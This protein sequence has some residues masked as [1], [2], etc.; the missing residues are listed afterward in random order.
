MTVVNLCNRLLF[1]GTCHDGCVSWQRRHL[2]VV[3]TAIFGGFL[4]APMMLG[5][6][7][8]RD[9][10]HAPVTAEPS[11]WHLDFKAAGALEE[12]E[13]VLAAA[14]KKGEEAVAAAQQRA[15]ERKAMGKKGAEEAVAAAKKKAEEAEAVAKAN[16]EVG[17]AAAKRGAEEL[18]V[19]K[20]RLEEMLAAAQH[21]VQEMEAA[22]NKSVEDALAAALSKAE[23]VKA[24]AQHNAE[25]AMAAAHLTAE[26]LGSAAGRQQATAK[27]AVAA[28]R[29]RADEMMAAANARVGMGQT[30]QE[31][32]AMDVP[33]SQHPAMI[34]STVFLVFITLMCSMVLSILPPILS[35]MTRHSQWRSFGLHTS[36]ADVWPAL[37]ITMLM[38]AMILE[39]LRANTISFSSSH[40]WMLAIAALCQWLGSIT[41]A[42]YTYCTMSHTL[43]SMSV[44]RQQLCVD[45]A[46]AAT[47]SSSLSKLL[48]QC[49]EQLHAQEK[50]IAELK[51]T[52][53]ERA[54]HH[55][56]G[57]NG[58][59]VELQNQTCRHVIGVELQN[60]PTIEDGL[61]AGQQTLDSNMPHSRAHDT[62]TVSSEWYSA[63]PIPPRSLEGW[64]IPP[65]SQGW[66]D[67]SRCAMYNDTLQDLWF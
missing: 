66:D 39:A 45:E 24:V 1:G 44:P 49:A 57:V 21:R 10:L 20:K 51:A 34:F 37:Q 60:G 64:D 50:E 25:V 55:V 46:E 23:E 9:E 16:A 53:R 35:L 18:T 32:A 29:K 2:L 48:Q 13:D 52:L 12:G 30:S 67:G 47:A 7:L 15:E 61:A 43:P 28:V 63:I 27:Q 36:S 41:N 8:H 65:Q 6:D 22:A 54:A 26:E 19:S 38:G 5:L 4:L 31:P 33:Q 14:K 58:I 42:R 59:G 11:V 56:I 3:V 17:V 62:D 40:G